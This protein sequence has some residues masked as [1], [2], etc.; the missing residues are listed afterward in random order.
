MGFFYIINEKIDHILTKI[1]K[2]GMILSI[3]SIFIITLS[4]VFNRYLL[5]TTLLS[6]YQEIDIFLYMILIFWGSSNV[7]K[8]NL[9][10]KFELLG[11]KL[12][13]ISKKRRID[14]YNI[15]R[16]L[17]NLFC[18]VISI[19]GVYYLSR[20][21]LLTKNV[22]PVL[23]IPT[24]YFFSIALVGGFVGLTLRYIGNV[25]NILKESKKYLL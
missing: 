5:K 18:L 22:T 20:F 16:I 21:V 4:E 14:F 19:M 8:G 11:L 7:A 17:N 2:T 15:Y 25:L 23:R 10:M 24:K 3:L 13:V 9:Q 6:W 1:E 12:K